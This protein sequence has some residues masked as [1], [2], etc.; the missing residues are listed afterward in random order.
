MEGVFIEGYTDED[1]NFTE[2]E[3]L[4]ENFLS[5]LQVV[6]TVWRIEKVGGI[7][8]NSTGERDGGGGGVSSGEGGGI[9]PQTIPSPHTTTTGSILV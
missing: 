4:L 6:R 8:C 9:S 7:P 3:D 2:C 5:W 1:G